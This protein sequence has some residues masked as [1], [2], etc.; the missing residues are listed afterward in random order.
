MKTG[1][2]PADNLNG[3]N[4]SLR[5]ITRALLMM[6]KSGPGGSDDGRGES[7]TRIDAC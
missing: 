3:F 2:C 6:D 4:R 1:Y 7:D 5:K